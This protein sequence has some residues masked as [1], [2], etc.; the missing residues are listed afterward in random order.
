M[1]SRLIKESI[2]WSEDIDKLNSFEETVFYRLILNCDDYGR[3]DARSNFL[4]SKLFVTKKG[5]TDKNVAE[6]V[7]KLASVGLVKLYEVDRKPFLLFPKWSLHQ[8]IRNSKEKYPAPQEKEFRGELPQVAASCGLNP[9]QS[10]SISESNIPPLSPTE[11]ECSSYASRFEQFWNA[12]PLK[13]AKG[14][15]EK[16]FLKHKPDDTLLS[17]MLKAVESQS[18]TKQWREEGGKYIPYPA[19]WLNQRRWEDEQDSGC[20]KKGSFTTGELDG[21]FLKPGEGDVDE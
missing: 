4:N 8:R 16:A 1:P 12:Y 17:V 19:T 18:K 14:A 7:S 15:A 2:C 20:E 11:G 3:I 9:I 6:A 5:I 21:L 13:K 10:E